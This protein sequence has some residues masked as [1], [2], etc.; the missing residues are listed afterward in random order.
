MLAGK[1]RNGGTRDGDDVTGAVKLLGR[2]VDMD[3]GTRADTTKRTAAA[4]RTGHNL[5]LDLSLK[6][7]I[8]EAVVLS[9]F[10]PS[11]LR[12]NDGTSSSIKPWR[13]LCGVRR[14]RAWK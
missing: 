9:T 5:K 12:K 10:V 4:V 14:A 6:G 1:W 3:G 13:Q 2:H 7:R 8:L 11:R